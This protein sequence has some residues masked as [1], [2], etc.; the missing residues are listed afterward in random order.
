[1]TCVFCFGGAKLWRS[2]RRV[3]VD[4]APTIAGFA[5]DQR[6]TAVR[7]IVDAFQSPASQDDGR[8]ITKRPDFEIG[9]SERA[10]L[11]A[12]G[13]F[14][15][16]TI[17]NRLPAAA[18][19]VFRNKGGGVRAGLAVSAG[20]TIHEAIDVAAVPGFLLRLKNGADLLLQRRSR[21]DRRCKNR[22]RNARRNGG[23]WT[24]DALQGL[25]AGVGVGVAVGDGVG[26]TSLRV[27]EGVGVTVGVG[28]G[29]GDSTASS[30][31]DVGADIGAI[32]M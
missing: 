25:N 27:R 13:I 19:F 3:V 9:E 11:G 12:I 2:R 26:V 6:K 1:M 20:I 31:K 30:P 17:T 21:N 10:H 8:I 28:D 4:D 23:N 32:A 5:K 14:F 7:L 29:D 15:L 18:D 24:H 22:R 16:V